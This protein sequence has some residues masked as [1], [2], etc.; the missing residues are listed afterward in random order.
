MSERFEI[1]VHGGS[2]V[3][4]QRII[5]DG[6][7]IADGEVRVDGNWVFWNRG[8]DFTADADEVWLRANIEKLPGV[9]CYLRW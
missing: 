8:F 2:V 7:S 4:V 1:E 3:E 5:Q 6:I 9:V